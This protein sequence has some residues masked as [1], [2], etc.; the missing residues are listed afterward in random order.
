MDIKSILP[1]QI[2]TMDY[3][4]IQMTIKSQIKTNL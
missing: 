3:Y 2:A 4:T 1:L